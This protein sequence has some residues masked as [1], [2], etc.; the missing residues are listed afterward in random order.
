MAGICFTA[1]CLFWS[2]EK[3]TGGQI[4]REGAQNL[5][6]TI[7]RQYMPQLSFLAEGR[8][9]Q[10]LAEVLV[11]RMER[12]V[13]VWS[14]AKSRSDYITASESS[15][16]YEEIIALEGKDEP[17]V[18][19]DLLE[20]A[21][22]ENVQVVAQ[23]T[24]TAGGKVQEI[25]R[26][27]LND[28]DYLIQNYYS[29][30][31]TTTITG[32]QLNAQELLGMDLTIKTPADQP[33]ILIYH[34]HSQEMYADSD[35]ADVMTGVMG[36]GEY[37]KQLL[38]GY[39]FQV[40]HH[41]GQ[42]DVGDRDHAYANAEDAIAQILEEN[43]SIEVVIDLH[44]DAV[45]QHMVRNVNG[46]DMAPVMFFNGLSYTNA[47]GNITYLDNPN[48]KGNL[49]FS[50]Q[51]QVA[52]KEYYPNLTR[53]IYL[54]GYRYNMHFREK[55]LLVELGSYTNTREEIYQALVPLADLLDR[56]LHG[57]GA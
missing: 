53:P 43:P 5:Q 42:Y 29:V 40:I 37:L 19:E 28:F 21:E 22:Q 50:L 41:M 52:A 24:V 49:A 51:M 11:A 12:Q 7:A 30:D 2:G 15:L 36:A 39:G 45:D 46:V 34:T 56:V 23:E 44:R 9:E 31:S 54:K 6:L 13:P 14:Y 33:Q 55:T 48:L 25:S 20:A 57:T 8:D 3:N 26:E 16:T 10:T 17:E 1:V 27:K 35:P 32:E 47:L 4:K 38:E 18:T